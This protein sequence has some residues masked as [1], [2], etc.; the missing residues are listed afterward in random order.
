MYRSEVC[1]NG[2]AKRVQ[3]YFLETCGWTIELFLVDE[4]NEVDYTK[5]EM[6]SSMVSCECGWMHNRHKF[7]YSLI[8]CPPRR[9]WL[10]Q[11]FSVVAVCAMNCVL[12]IQ[13]RTRLDWHCNDVEDNMHWCDHMHQTGIYGCSCDVLHILNNIMEIIHSVLIRNNVVD[14]SM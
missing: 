5:N 10:L 12:R 8:P 3:P 11:N 4:W 13:W 6:M 7:V 1:D 14:G 9:V 2:H